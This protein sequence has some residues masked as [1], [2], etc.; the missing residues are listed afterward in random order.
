MRNSLKI[1]K[2]ANLDKSNNINLSDFMLN[3]EEK[4]NY[5]NDYMSRDEEQD[6]TINN[7]KNK[8]NALNSS[9]IKRR[10]NMNKI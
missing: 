5:N 6:L 10:R 1:K 8:N 3:N 9:E 4:I 7:K 2:S